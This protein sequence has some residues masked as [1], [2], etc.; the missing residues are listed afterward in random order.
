MK[1][2]F[3]AIAGSERVPLPGAVATGRAN[4]HATIAVSLKLRRKQPL[5]PMTIGLGAAMTRRELGEHYGADQADID[6][7]VQDFEKL[8]L[9]AAA[10]NAATRTVELC[11]TVA[12]MENAFGV[13]L[14]S[15]NHES[16]SYRGRVGALHVP[17]G[18]E[19]IVQGVFGLDNRRVARQR[20]QPAHDHHAHVRLG[21]VPSAWYV[22]SELA[23]H[24][25][26]PEGDGAGQTVGLLEF[27]GGYFPADLQKFCAMAK[28]PVLPIVT[29]I[30]T[31]GTATDSR[32][33]AEGEVMLDVEVIAGLCP[34]ADIAVYFAQWTEQGW[35]TALDAAVHDQQNDPGVI[36]I[37]WGGTEDSGLWTQSAMDQ[38]NETLREA[39]ALGVT[40]CVAAGDDGSSNAVPDGHAHVDF[41]ASSPY[42]L[43]VGG[44]T[45]PTKA[46]RRPDIAWK[47]GD[48]LR[49]DN[50]G[51]TGGGVSA[52]FPVPSWQAP[53]AVAPINP[54][55]IAG[56]CIPDIAA[57]ADWNASPY[58]LVVDGRAQPNGGTSAASPLVAGLITLINAQRGPGKRVGYVTPV[59]YQTLPGDGTTTVGAAGCTDVTSGENVTSQ[60]GGYA[61]GPG[62]DAVSG[63]GT[64]DG[65][66]L[67][68]ALAA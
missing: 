39:A 56:R 66:R 54:G 28:I 45:I 53:F 4:P 34:K 16:G 51:S 11:G 32:D 59:L 52:V 5:P 8:G 63:W 14:F 2:D 7:V 55:A 19:H 40:V 68:E 29:A 64:P 48:G 46:R 58:L 25:H 26:Y 44:T 10:T 67:A 30:S 21:S 43:A 22:P 36:S 62:Y 42:V 50:G 17:T 12:E 33:G 57:N 31:D 23:A 41:P 3:A 18:L 1:T 49:A 13:K 9:K 65:V 38:V 6:M 15:Y 27:G 47:E 60:V 20:R 61:A 24:Y 37:S 35:I